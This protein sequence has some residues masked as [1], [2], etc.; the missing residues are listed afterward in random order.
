M[1]LLF[2]FLWTEILVC[3]VAQTMNVLNTQIMNA[4]SKFYYHLVE[5][6]CKSSVVGKF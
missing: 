4:T 2:H 3:V 1:F 5:L 6:L